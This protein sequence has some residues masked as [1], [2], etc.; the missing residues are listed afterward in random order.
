VK[1]EADLEIEKA[2]LHGRP[3]LRLQGLVDFRTSPRLREPLR[4]WVR[5]G[6]E[7]GVINLKGLEKIDTTGVATIVE[8][9]RDLHEHGGRLVLVNDSAAVR[10]A[11][12]LSDAGDCC[13]RC[14]TEEEAAQL[15]QDRTGKEQ[16]A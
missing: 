11:L 7:T 12:E 13:R 4:R 1:Q 15:L 5:E 3:L 6:V 8:T 10:R 14:R 9:A 2:E 16:E